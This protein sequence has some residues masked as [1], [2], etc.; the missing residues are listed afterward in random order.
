MIVENLITKVHK[1]GNYGYPKTWKQVNIMPRWS[2]C[3]I[4]F[5]GKR[6]GN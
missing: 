1:I 4:S 3:V 6:Y 2:K 5:K